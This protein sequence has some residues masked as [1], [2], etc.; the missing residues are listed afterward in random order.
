LKQNKPIL[1]TGS[2]NGERIEPVDTKRLLPNEISE[3]VDKGVYDEDSPHRCFTQGKGYHGG[4][5]PHLVN[6]FIK[7]IIKSRDSSIDVEKTVNW[8]CA[9]ICSHESAKNREKDIFTKNI[10]E[11]EY[12][13]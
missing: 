13:L 2:E 6:E 12:L 3:H 1:F 4:S 11:C 10:I 8:T 9:G 5:H 7:S